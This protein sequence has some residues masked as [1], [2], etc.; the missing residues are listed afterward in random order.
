MSS[1]D[2]ERVIEIRAME[3]SL[4]CRPRLTSK[5]PA[6]LAVSRNPEKK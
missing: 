5:S 1:A 6:G 3:K 2:R 4:G